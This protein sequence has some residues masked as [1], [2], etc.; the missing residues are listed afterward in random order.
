MESV[1]EYEREYSKE[2]EVRQ[3]EAKED[4]KMFSRELLGRYIAKLLYRWRNKK[5][6]REY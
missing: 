6:N 5:Y 4:R 1:E 3:Q 2:E